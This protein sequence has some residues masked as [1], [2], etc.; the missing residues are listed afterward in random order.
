MAYDSTS[1][2]FKELAE[3]P[4]APRWFVKF[5]HF[6]NEMLGLD[7]CALSASCLSF[8]SIIYWSKA[9]KFKVTQKRWLCLWL[10]FDV[11]AALS[12]LFFFLHVA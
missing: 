12:N 5:Y 3:F 9:K 6:K 1:G 7:I 10:M 8:A 11:P 2:D 4:H